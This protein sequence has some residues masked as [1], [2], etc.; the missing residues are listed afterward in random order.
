M[1][2]IDQIHALRSEIER[3]LAAIASLE[4][5]ERFRLL[6]MVKKGR[7]QVLTDALRTVPKDEKPTVGKS[8][9]ELRKL[10]EG[11]FEDARAQYE[12]RRSTQR[13]DVT[14]P[15]RQIA[16]GSLHPITQTLDRIVDIFTSM[17]FDV[18]ESFDIEDDAHNFG[19]LNFAE[20]HPARDMQDTFFIDD[21][22]RQD[23]VLRTHT[24]SVQIR[25]MEEMKPPIRC[26]MPGRVYRNEAVSA[27]SL[28]EFHQI[29][30]LYIDK[31][32]SMADLKGTIMAF[33]QRMYSSDARFRFRTSY[34]P[35]TEPSAEVDMSCFICKGQG[36]RI[37]K[38]SG[39]LEICGCGMVHPNVLRNC[40]I[41]P[42]EYSG[43][44]FGFGI[45]RVTMMLTG[46]DDIR[47]LYDN[48]TRV[49]RQF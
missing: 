43:F 2:M 14:L 24:S 20:D 34:F 26:I 47:M 48:D 44:A 31:G 12:R 9:N 42:E 23:L 4:D 22:D 16:T 13:I 8:L 7:L 10:A 17:G 3:D 36:C 29:E 27:R 28:A 41:D 18:A 1:T 19:K 39:W 38:H 49:L 40:G 6:H 5:L 30:G 35:F 11:G 33:A 46:I 45:E 37:C 15:G 21:P 32:V 25:V